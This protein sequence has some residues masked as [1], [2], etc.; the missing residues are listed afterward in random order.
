MH[1]VLPIDIASVT[2]RRYFK[3]IYIYIKSVLAF[4]LIDL[5]IYLN[6]KNVKIV[7]IS[8]HNFFQFI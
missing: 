4:L 6:K 7:L 3:N 2:N 5:F 1:S 8:C